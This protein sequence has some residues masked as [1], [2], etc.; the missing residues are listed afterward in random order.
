[1]TPGGSEKHWVD[2]NNIFFAE[3]FSDSFVKKNFEYRACECFFWQFLVVIL[4]VNNPGIEA[5]SCDLN[6]NSQCL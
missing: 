6:S 3:V 2:I 4:L 5:S 1:M